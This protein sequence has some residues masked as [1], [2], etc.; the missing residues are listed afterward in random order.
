MGLNNIGNTA[1]LVDGEKSGKEY[2]YSVKDHAD[3]LLAHTEVEEYAA[4]S[5]RS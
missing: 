4:V 1:Q 5:F 2:T 3:Y